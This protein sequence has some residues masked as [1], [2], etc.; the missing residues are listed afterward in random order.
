MTK[1][2][3]KMRQV[4]VD[5]AVIDMRL[6]L[7]QL[8]LREW[9]FANCPAIPFWA[10]QYGDPDLGHVFKI[11]KELETRADEREPA[12]QG[13][14]TEYTIAGRKAPARDFLFGGQSSLGQVIAEATLQLL[15]EGAPETA[16]VAAEQA[17]DL[18]TA[19]DPDVPPLT[20]LA[21]E[22]ADQFE[23]PWTN[24]GDV[25]Q[26]S[27]NLLPALAGSLTDKQVATEAFWPTIASFGLPF[28]LLVLKKLPMPGA[29]DPADSLVGGD[30][31]A[32]AGPLYEIDMRHLGSLEPA[33]LIH[34]DGTPEIR[35]VPGTRTLLE[36]DSKTK[37]LK[38][39]RIEILQK[40]GPPLLYQ[41]KDPA[42]LYALQAAKASIAVHG[43]WLGHVY[44]WH[45]VTAAMQ[46]TMY[47]TLPPDNRLWPLLSPQSEYLIDFD[48]V[49]LMFLWGKITPPTP[50]YGYMPLLRL[51]DEYS[52]DRSFFADDPHSMLEQQGISPADFK[53][54]RDWDAYPLAGFL[55]EIWD[56]TSAYVTAVVGELYKT[57]DEVK[58]DAGL[59]AWIQASAD[60]ARGNIQG[61]TPPATRDQLVKILTSLLY[62]VTAHGASSLVPSVNPALSFVANLPPC[63]QSDKIPAPGAKLSEKQLLALLPHTG[64]LGAVTNF[65]FTFA[66]TKPFEPFIPLGGVSQDPYFPPQQ[67]DCNEALIAYR[68]RIYDFVDEYEFE[69][70]LALARLRGW[71]EP[72]PA[73]AKKQ[74]HQWARSIE[75]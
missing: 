21:L 11:L 15:P 69:W 43:T 45:I 52:E 66:Y 25:R 33:T 12:L 6:K 23:L 63:L 54:H 17:D 65:Y 50:V 37:A 13:L 51:L 41:F 53:V 16:T 3:P 27:Q 38:P 73:Y 74:H 10:D 22:K 35:F 29:G 67:K 26:L 62:R 2:K 8:P 28:N 24:Y 40:D 64:S 58:K 9:N 18:R 32:A 71:A 72:P 39:V 75:I 49:L 34:P 70:D 20:L 61:L 1:V 4:S 44:P 48:F 42:W 59:K 46:M 57:D 5:G 19:A 55:L 47:N 31:D 14:S 7:S 56:A 60:S 68:Q 30:R 36:Q